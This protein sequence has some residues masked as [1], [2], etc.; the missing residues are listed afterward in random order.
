MHSKV[1]LLDLNLQSTSLKR[2]SNR[3]FSK[4]SWVTASPLVVNALLPS[5]SK[6][7]HGFLTRILGPKSM[8]KFR[9]QSLCFGT[10]S[11]IITTSLKSIYPA[12]RS[13][14]AAKIRRMRSQRRLTWSSSLP[15]LAQKRLGL[16]GEEAY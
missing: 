6:N 10:P 16:K 1:V 13:D 7:F 4:I 8:D 12:V 14:I 15:A 5:M 11:H 2:I 9:E 3:S